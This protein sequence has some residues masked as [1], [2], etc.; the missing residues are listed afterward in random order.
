VWDWGGRNTAS[1]DRSI[2][3]PKSTPLPPTTIQALAQVAD[4]K[5]ENA[6]LEYRILHLL[7]AL[8]ALEAEK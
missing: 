4:L 1:S 6:R 8:N 3:Q 5:K 7:R 2:D